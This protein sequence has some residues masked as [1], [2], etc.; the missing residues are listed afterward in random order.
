MEHIQQPGCSYRPLH[1]LFLGGPQY[2]GENDEEFLNKEG[3]NL[4]SL[5][6]AIYNPLDPWFVHNTT[7]QSASDFYDLLCSRLPE[8]DKRQ[9]ILPIKIAQATLEIA[10]S[11]LSKVGVP[12]TS[13]S[14]DG[15]SEQDQVST[16]FSVFDAMQALESSP[17][18]HPP[19][20]ITTTATNPK[21]ARSFLQK[22]AYLTPHYRSWCFSL[23][24]INEDTLVPLAWLQSSE[25]ILE[26]FEGL[27]LEKGSSENSQDSHSS[28]TENTLSAG[29]LDQPLSLYRENSPLAC[30]TKAFKVKNID[31]E[32]QGSEDLSKHATAQEPGDGA[33]D[34]SG[35]GAKK[36]N[37]RPHSAYQDF[38][39]LFASQDRSRSTLAPWELPPETFVVRHL[40]AEQNDP[41]TIPR[42]DRGWVRSLT[43]MTPRADESALIMY[44]RPW[45]PPNPSDD[46]SPMNPPAEENLVKAMAILQQVIFFG[47]LRRFFRAAG[48]NL[49]PEYYRAVVNGQR[50]IT[51]DR[52]RRQCYYWSC[53]VRALDRES[54]QEAIR[55]ACVVLSK[56]NDALWTL[57]ERGGTPVESGLTFVVGVLCE[58][59]KLVVANVAEHYPTGLKSIGGSF[60]DLILARNF[61]LCGASIGRIRRKFPS[62]T[63]KY[64]FYLLG[65]SQAPRDHSKCE[66]NCIANQIDN[67][68]YEPQHHVQKDGTCLCEHLAPHLVERAADLDPEARIRLLF[69]PPSRTSRTSFDARRYHSSLCGP[70]PVHRPLYAHC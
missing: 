5:Y 59:L 65:P 47:T 34:K 8:K 48:L 37:W 38:Y 6:S 58:H 69:P 16:L 44:L 55:K 18:P 32:A 51:T 26:L 50:V 43:L 57:E 36:S 9:H 30:E 41:Y 64:Y 35:E 7:F 68:A 19:N 62:L 28:T 33:E 66:E 25:G 20:L 3:W 13:L 22:L 4:S 56:T 42:G 23:A 11:A 60:L 27:S 53:A 40:I 17:A 21:V 52:L 49:S 29:L 14:N 15:G 67:E 63:L 31:G 12:R 24:H 45:V 54:K 39:G 61:E 10:R 1:F 70:L 46:Q 2:D